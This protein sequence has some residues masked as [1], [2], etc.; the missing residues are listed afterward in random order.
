MLVETE[1][2]ILAM[3]F[4]WCDG[5]LLLFL[6]LMLRSER[7]WHWHAL[8]DAQLILHSLPTLGEKKLLNDLCRF[9]QKKKWELSGL[10]NRPSTTPRGFM[11]ISAQLILI[12]QLQEFM[13][14]KGYE[15]K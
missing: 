6:G 11:V 3:L 14:S 12:E 13:K 5:W 15:Q 4:F 7:P 9:L 1:S 10:N 2:S 8:K